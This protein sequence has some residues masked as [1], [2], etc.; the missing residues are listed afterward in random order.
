MTFIIYACKRENEMSNFICD[1][2]GTHII[3]SETGYTTQCKHYPKPLKKGDVCYIHG[4]SFEVVDVLLAHYRVRQRGTKK[5][6]FII[7]R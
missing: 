3:D 7:P 5:K 1:K 4:V 2:C 6:T